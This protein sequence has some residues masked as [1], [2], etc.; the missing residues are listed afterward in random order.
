MTSSATTRVC[1]AL[2]ERGI[3]IP[4]LALIRTVANFGVAIR[5]PDE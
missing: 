4:I 1:E 5:V 2:R 3:D